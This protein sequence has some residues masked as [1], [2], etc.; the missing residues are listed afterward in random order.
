MWAISPGNLPIMNI[1]VPVLQWNPMSDS[2]AALAPS[3][4]RCIFLEL[5]SIFSISFANSVCGPVHFSSFPI[6][7]IFVALG[8]LWWYL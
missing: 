4:F 7:N 2:I 3:I 1:P 6:F 8:S 5:Y